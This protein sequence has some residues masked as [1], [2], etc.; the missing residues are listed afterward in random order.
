VVAAAL[1]KTNGDFQLLDIWTA[2]S[3]SLHGNAGLSEWPVIEPSSARTELKRE[4][5]KGKDLSKSKVKDTMFP[6]VEKNIIDQLARTRRF[7]PHLMNTGG[8]YV[9]VFQ[10]ISGNAK[11]KNYEDKAEHIREID[12]ETFA[13]LRNFYGLP[14]ELKELLVVPKEAEKR[15]SLVTKSLKE[16]LMNTDPTVK[17]V[18]V[19]VRAFQTLTNSAVNFRLT[20][21]G[22]RAMWKL[23]T[24]RVVHVEPEIFRELL[25]KREITPEKLTGCPGWNTVADECGPAVVVCR[26]IPLACMA[27]ARSVQVFTDK[28]YTEALLGMLQEI[29]FH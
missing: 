10:R 26:E 9:A 8:F 3:D 2:L 20:Q 25:T 29:E 13:A 15:I 27:F 21:E 18:S 4:D 19:G 24:Q 28:Q 6:P 11:H 23:M 14:E 5:F 1:A 12:D 16:T 17:V 22:A 7:L